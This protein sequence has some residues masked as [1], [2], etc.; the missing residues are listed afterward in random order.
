MWPGPT[1][2]ISLG[3]AAAAPVGTTHASAA[4]A[5]ATMPGLANFLAVL[6]P[7]MSDPFPVRV[8]G[9]QGRSELQKRGR[10]EDQDFASGS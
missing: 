4:I 8:I 1:L 9:S 6:L 3:V 7:V 10:R 2:A 5:F